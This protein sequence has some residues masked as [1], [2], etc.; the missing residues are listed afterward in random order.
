MWGISNF[1]IDGS[2]VLK[3]IVYLESKLD[4]FVKFLAGSVKLW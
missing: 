3:E 4:I 1:F 2:P